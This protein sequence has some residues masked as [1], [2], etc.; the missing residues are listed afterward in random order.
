MN[1]DRKLQLV[2]WGLSVVTV[3]LAIT[4]WGEGNNWH[5]THISTYNLFPIFGLVAFSLMWGHYIVAALRVWL[6]VD[7]EVTKSYFE[8]T[9]LVVLACIL[10][11]PGL[12][13]YRLFHDGAG[14]PPESYIHYVKPSLKW[15]V[16]LGSISFAIFLLYEF[17]RI[18]D[19]KPWW[20]FVQYASDAAMFFIVIHALAL[21]R[22]LGPGWFRIVWVF[23]AVGLFVSTIYMYNEKRKPPSKKA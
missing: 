16:L 21:G 22:Q 17:H 4:A 6:K 14:L 3:L 1:K 2:A 11:H 13:V 15:A 23:Y 5:I 8:I 20:K 10:L 7:K 9:S 18:Y 12:L 19:K